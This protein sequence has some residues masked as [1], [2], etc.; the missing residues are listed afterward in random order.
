MK[1]LVT[2]GAGFIGSWT[3]E[4][5]IKAG[6]E[7]IVV[8]DLS[9][10]DLGNLR[11]IAKNIVF[12]NADVRDRG[13]VEEVFR[14]HGPDAVIHLAAVV[15]VD[16]VAE[17]P[18][19]GFEVNVHGTLNLLEVARRHSVNV[20]VYA[21]SAA[22]YGDPL[23]LPITE[24]H[25]TRPKNVYG[26][27]KLA[28]EALVN[29][30]RGSYGI[31][32]VVLRY[33]NV[34]G[35]RMRPGPYAGVIRK[36]IEAVLGNKPITIFGDG[37][38]TRDFIY[39]EDVARANL[40]ALESGA[41]GI[42]NIGTGIPTKIVDLAYT[43]MEIAGKEVPIIYADTRPGDIMHSYADI[44]RAKDE[45]GWYPKTG[46]KDGLRKTFEELSKSLNYI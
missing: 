18:V 3:V 35:P 1:I 23:E 31:R 17:D 30:Y 21:S 13:A 8:D 39:V 40:A 46:L 14:A 42:Y 7:A 22:V 10:G 20:F 2:G 28:G 24:E 45:L 29:A 9:T 27:T 36:F 15:S 26:A 6:H 4:A 37:E 5:V 19:R 38:Q 16:E 25:P 32:A 33:F 12:V 44:S 34:Y 43:I 41:A 11:G